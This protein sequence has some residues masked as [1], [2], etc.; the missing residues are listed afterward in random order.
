MPQQI[1]NLF[2]AKGARSGQLSHRSH[3]AL[4]HNEVILVAPQ[5]HRPKPLIRLDQTADEFY[6]AMDEMLLH[7]G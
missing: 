4:F 3:N 1:C 2:L 7:P 6:R 5:R